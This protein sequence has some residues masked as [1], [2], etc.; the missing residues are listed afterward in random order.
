M[1]SIIEAVEDIFQD[2]SALVKFAVY[3]APL[4]FTNNFQA[5]AA[6]LQVCLAAMSMN[7]VILPARIRTDISVA[8]FSVVARR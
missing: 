5:S 6:G 8:H 2:G 4:F 3:G 7:L 1:A